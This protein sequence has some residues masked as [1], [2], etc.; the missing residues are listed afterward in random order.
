MKLS[1]LV[2]VTAAILCLSACETAEGYRKQLTQYQGEAVKQLIAEW[3]E[4][5]IVNRL[6]DGREVWIYERVRDLPRGGYFEH[7]Y[8]RKSA[9]FEDKDGDV[10][11]RRFMEARRV[12]V[13]RYTLRSE[14]RTHF[15]VEKNDVVAEFTFRGNGCLASEWGI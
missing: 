3:G 12:W 14:C 10:E 8:Y 15:I 5:K 6:D 9:K 2:S 7:K 1:T 11:T 4:P 13:P